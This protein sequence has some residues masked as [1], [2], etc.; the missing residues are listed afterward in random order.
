[1]TNLPTPANRFRAALSGFADRMRESAARA[2]T[3]RALA[4]LNDA[5]LRDIGISRSEALSIAFGGDLE[6]RRS[7][8]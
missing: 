6:R 4:N 3:R 1:M 8:D 2:R 7:R 5:T